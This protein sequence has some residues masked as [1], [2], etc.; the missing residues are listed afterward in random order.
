MNEGGSENFIKTKKKKRKRK[1]KGSRHPQSILICPFRVITVMAF[2]HRTR[3]Q[4]KIRKTNEIDPVSYSDDISTTLKM[5]H[6]FAI[7]FRLLLY[8]YFSFL[9]CVR[10]RGISANITRRTKNIFVGF[11][12][13]VRSFVH[14]SFIWR[15]KRFSVAFW[16]FSFF[17][18]RENKKNCWMREIGFSRECRGGSLRPS[19]PL[20][21][22]GLW[23]A[24]IRLKKNFD[25]DNW[26]IKSQS[27][28]IEML[29]VFR[30]RNPG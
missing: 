5:A 12:P 29:C 4:E 13:F 18:L 20:I 25:A 10:A 6:I 2:W 22:T 23:T 8:D 1:K 11:I 9:L 27:L 14:M 15:G 26:G 30:C 3:F 24:G 7:I 28:L 21:A 17:F 19:R 16:C